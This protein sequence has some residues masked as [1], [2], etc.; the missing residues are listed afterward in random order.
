[1]QDDAALLW[2]AGTVQSLV[3]VVE[4]ALQ[5]TQS[6]WPFNCE[7]DA[8]RTVMRF[9]VICTCTEPNSAGLSKIRIWL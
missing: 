7:T 9:G 5:A 2:N 4:I 3:K 8:G 1:M 6:L